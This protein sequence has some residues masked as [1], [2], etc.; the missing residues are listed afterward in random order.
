M[1]GTLKAYVGDIAVPSVSVSVEFRHLANVFE[2]AR[3]IW[4]V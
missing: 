1:E 4:I 3:H 2:N